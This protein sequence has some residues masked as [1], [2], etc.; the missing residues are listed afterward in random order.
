MRLQC[1][2]IPHAAMRAGQIQMLRCTGAQVVQELAAIHFCNKALLVQHRH[3]Q[4]AVE[5]FVAGFTVDAD[6]LQAGSDLGAFDAVL[7]RQAQAQ[8]AVGETQLEVLCGFRRSDAARLEI[9]QRLGAGFE[10]VVVVIHDLVEQGLIVG[11]DRHRRTEGAH[12][13]ALDCTRPGG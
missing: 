10:G 8:G 3:D 4:R 11:I 6:F 7:L 13:G 1:C 9:R 12:R 2:N 5:V